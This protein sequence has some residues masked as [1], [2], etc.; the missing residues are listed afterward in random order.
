VSADEDVKRGFSWIKHYK[1]LSGEK[2]PRCCAFKPQIKSSGLRIGPCDNVNPLRGAHVLIGR[3]RNNRTQQIVPVCKRHNDD[4]HSFFN[5][6]DLMKIKATY[7]VRARKK[8]TE[9]QQRSSWFRK[10]SKK[11]KKKTLS[12]SKYSKKD[13]WNLARRNSQKTFTWDG[14]SNLKVSSFYVKRST[15]RLVKRK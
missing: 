11:R 6:G 4:R 3:K 7:A 13:T 12:K 1:I 8:L 5:N 14:N 15:N 10:K 2:N 9:D